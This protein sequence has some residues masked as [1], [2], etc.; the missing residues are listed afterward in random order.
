MREVYDHGTWYVDPA[1]GA[2]CLTKP[3]SRELGV[4]PDVLL[5]VPSE[6]VGTLI[7]LLKE[8]GVVPTLDM[9][10]NKDLLAIINRLLNQTEKAMPKAKAK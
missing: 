5:E 9:E 8:R 1:K 7:D 2:Y 4:V 10:I 6:H 3:G